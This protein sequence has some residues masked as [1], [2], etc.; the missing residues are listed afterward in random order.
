MY[1]FEKQEIETIVENVGFIQT[2]IVDDGENSASTMLYSSGDQLRVLEAGI[3]VPEE[4]KTEKTFFKKNRLAGFESHP[5]FSAVSERMD[6]NVS[7]IME[8][9]KRVFLD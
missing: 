1:D 4:L 9:A 2:S 6:A 3:P 5:D 8:T 7:G